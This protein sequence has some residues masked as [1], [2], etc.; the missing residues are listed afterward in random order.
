MFGASR[1]STC[2]FAFAK[3]GEA[4]AVMKDILWARTRGIPRVNVE[5]DVE[6]ISLFCG[7]GVADVSWTTKAIL[8][9]CLQG[10]REAS[11][12][13]NRTW[14][15]NAPQPLPSS[16]IAPQ[17]DPTAFA[18]SL[19]ELGALVLSTSD[20]LT[21]AK[22]SHLAYSRWRRENLPLGVFKPPDRPARP[23]KPQLVTSMLITN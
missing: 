4:L 22:L 11:L 6:A 3:E 12:N 20:P 18:S 5:T 21:K 15:S 17:D 23:P 1:G 14:G 13:E 8:Q 2:R 19:S 7:N 16:S 9:D 10:W